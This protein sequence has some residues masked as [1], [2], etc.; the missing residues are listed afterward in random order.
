MSITTFMSL[1][2]PTVSVTLGPEW[3]TELNAALET[4]DAHDHTSGKGRPITTSALSIDAD[5]DF[6][7][8][9]AIDLRSSQYTNLVTPLSGAT[10]ASSVY[11]SGGNLYYTN[12]SGVVVQITSGGS[13]VTTPASVEAF[14]FDAVSNDLVI[15][16]GDSTLFV[17]MN[18]SAPRSV[19]LP[20]AASVAAGRLY[21][22]ADATGQSESNTLT[23]SASGSDLIDGASSDAVTSNYSARAY[24]SDGVSTYKVW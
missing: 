1:E 7:L 8:F 17:N 11:V 9:R 2:L 5:L 23:V 20:L 21:I 16:A 4:V 14:Q 22:I 15:G 18:M 12:S 10:N 19:T 6:N 24:I 3:A 13:V